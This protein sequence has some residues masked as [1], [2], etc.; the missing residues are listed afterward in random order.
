MLDNIDKQ[1][2]LPLYS[3][4]AGILKGKI[5]S[6]QWE[7]HFKL[8]A[9]RE[10]CELYGVSRATVRQAL[11]ELEDKG[12]IYKSRGLGTFVKPRKIRQDLLNIYSFTEEMRK[13]GKV[14]SSKV[15]DFALIPCNEKVAKKLKVDEGTLVFY[16]VRLR[17]ADGEPMMI[18]TSYL[19]YSRFPN[20]NVEKLET[21]PVGTIMMEEHNAVFTRVEERFVPLLTR[22]DEA[23]LLQVA[24]N[25][26]GMKIE[27]ISYERDLVIEYAVA[28]ARGDRF[29]YR[30]VLT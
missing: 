11:H 10:L 15:L 5:E 1:S 29:E 7:E 4:L 24:P 30:V 18:Q 16:F 17:L 19:P 28:I 2:P 6:N 27:R 13:I 12:F 20:I 22:K 25:S 23:E 21:T 26:L 8:P 14:P 9:E 3:Q